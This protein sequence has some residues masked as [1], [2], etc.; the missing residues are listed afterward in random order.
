MAAYRLTQP[1]RSD[2]VRVLT[3]SQD[4]FGIQARMRYRALIDAAINDIAVEPT[5]VGSTE[6]PE[7]GDGVRTWHL[8]LSRDRS[9]AEPVHQ[10]RHFLIYKLDQDVVVIG[11]VLHDIM[12]LAR[13]VEPDTIWE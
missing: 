2:I 8:R 10:P 12:D 4:R 11:R 5:R 6:R 13:H 3:W 7:L 9:S 1:A